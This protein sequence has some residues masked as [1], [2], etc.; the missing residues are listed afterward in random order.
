MS[1]PDSENLTPES[2]SPSQGMPLPFDPLTFL[3]G[4]WVRRWIFVAVVIAAGIVAV[5]VAISEGQR[6]YVA[7]ALLLYEPRQDSGGEGENAG[8]DRSLG[9]SLH[10]LV[11]LVKTRSNLERVREKLALHASISQIG[12]AI[13]VELRRT[14][15]LI[16]IKA[17]WSD[18][19]TAAALAN[20][21]AMVFQESLQEMKKG[22]LAGEAKGL[23]HRL[24]DVD[25][26]LDRADSQLQKF[27]LDNRILDVDKETEWY[28]TQ[29]NTLATLRE[30]ATSKKRSLQKQYND[31][32]KIMDELKE[33]AAAEQ[34]NQA[35]K[36]AST[37]EN[38]V[39]IQRLRELID[40]ERTHKAREADMIVREQDLKRAQ[41]L[42][43]LE[44][45]SQSE[46]EKIK[47][48]YDRAKA[49]I[50]ESAD[51]KKWQAQIKQLD[52]TIV[53]QNGEPTASGR[54]LEEMMLRVFDLRL[55]G[56]ALDE[57]AKYLE[58]AYQRTRDRAER[59]PSFR[60]RLTELN[61]KVVRLEEEKRM[62]ST[63]LDETNRRIAD[64]D[65]GFDLVSHAAKPIYPKKSNRKLLFLGVLFLGI[66]AGLALVILLTFLDRR[67]KS[68]GDLH[69]SLPSEVYA[70]LRLGEDRCSSS[71][72]RRAIVRLRTVF[73][74]RSTALLVASDAQNQH[75]RWVTADLATL[76]YE[77]GEQVLIIEADGAGEIETEEEL[78]LPFLRIESLQKCAELHMPKAPVSP[79]TVG[80]S[81]H[82]GEAT[83]Y[84]DLPMSYNVSGWEDVAE[85]AT[86]FDGNLPE[87]LTI[88]VVSVA[89]LTPE[90]LGSRKFAR[91]FERVRNSYSLVLFDIQLN[92]SNVMAEYLLTYSDA[93]V[94]VAEA[95][96]TRIGRA[97]AAA[98]RVREY[99]KSIVCAVLDGVQKP[100]W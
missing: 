92:E 10:T 93:V 5:I 15:S 57:E 17:T 56:I 14:T 65:T 47:A 18:P 32:D 44:A 88:D 74:R 70:T 54:M 23:Q 42:Y 41:K 16:T 78:S 95:E 49:L 60:R 26:R 33:R 89:E 69:L 37:T 63:R 87:D 72:L 29:L 2:G 38:N 68:T 25:S 84:G 40:E 83:R 39:K 67:I 86:P 8:G 22:K 53:P 43:D 4:L 79:E 36:L 31:I 75:R 45:I 99:G 98:R 82:A 81:R 46:Y 28:L 11:N 1:S 52:Q 48:E 61:R 64:P 34:E 27:I 55:K 35:S 30:E 50:E 20:T 21:M 51:I 59:L 100:Y 62:L 90:R 73:S 13:D 19:D 12:Q 7:D 80:V 97:K 91:L 76:F 66:G 77:R 85:D 96:H 94:F 71:D 9:Y 6:V 24:D 58:E 3:V